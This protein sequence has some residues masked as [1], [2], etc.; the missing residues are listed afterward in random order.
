MPQEASMWESNCIGC[1]NIIEGM[2]V[3]AMVVAVA[4][5]VV[6]PIVRRVH[7]VVV[8]LAPGKLAACHLGEEEVD[9]V[10]QGAVL[11]MTTMV[12]T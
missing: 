1:A 3:R 6:V 2:L 12:S 11:Q 7:V 10:G 8:V 9:S 4:V 5:A